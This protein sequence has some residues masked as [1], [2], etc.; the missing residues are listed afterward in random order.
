MSPCRST[1]RA[2]PAPPSAGLWLISSSRS[3]WFG[4][5]LCDNESYP[6]GNPVCTTTDANIQVPPRPDHAG[7]AFAELQ[8]YPPGYA[9]FIKKISCDMTHWCAAMAIFSLQAQFGALHGP[10]SPPGALANNNCVEPANFAFLTLSGNPVRPPGP[11][12]ATSGTFSPNKDT[13]LMNQGDRSGHTSRHLRRPPQRDHGPHHW[14]DREDVAC[15]EPSGQG[16]LCRVFTGR[17]GIKCLGNTRNSRRSSGKRLPGW[18]CSLPLGSWVKA[19]REKHAEDEPPL[20]LSERARLRELEKEVRELRVK[21]EFLS[22]AAAY[23][24]VEHR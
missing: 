2:L 9:P 1:R 13:F 8:L 6:E 15:P 12:T 22:K 17:D 20:Q 23:F 14:T 16:A 18:W 7:A 24:A 3:P 19:Y 4:M 10:A 21:A 11:D 5:V